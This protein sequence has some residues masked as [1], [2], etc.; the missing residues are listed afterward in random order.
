MRVNDIV[1]VGKALEKKSNWEGME[2]LG[3]LARKQYPDTMLGNYYLALSFEKSGEPKKA[4][5]TY[6][7]AYL[8][9][10]ISFLTKDLMLD[11][12]DQIKSDFGY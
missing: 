10:E 11:K 12:A 2:Q 6:Q 8:L 4:M 3:Q 9:E 7:N 5:R 1:A